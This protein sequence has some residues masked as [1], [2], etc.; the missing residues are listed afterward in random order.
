MTVDGKKQCSKC[1]EI[2]DVSVFYRRRARGDNG[3]MSA[4]ISCS[5]IAK[6]QWRVS[7]KKEHNEQARVYRNKMWDEILDAYGPLCACCGEQNR[8]FLTLDHVDGGG[9][10]HIESVGHK[11]IR[12]QIRAFVRRTGKPDTRYQVLCFNCNCGRS[13][14]GGIC[15]HKLILKGTNV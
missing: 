3:R 8:R 14:N 4:C 15:P 10:K 11:T 5:S 9:R 13:L 1:K 7:H 6:E 2:L 12:I